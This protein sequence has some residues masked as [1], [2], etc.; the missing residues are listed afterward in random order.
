LFPGG[1][2]WPCA[3]LRASA[4]LQEVLLGER[5]GLAHLSYRRALTLA[6]REATPATWRG[7]LTAAKNLRGATRDQRRNAAAERGE[8][9]V[10]CPHV[11]GTIVKLPITTTLRVRWPDLARELE[12]SR[13]LVARSRELVEE[14]RRL[15]TSI[16][17]ENDLGGG[18]RS[19]MPPPE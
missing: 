14:S 13:Q 10:A 12:R 17:T 2:N 16:I 6:Q 5:L 18:R 9:E 7:L 1:P 3:A 19:A 11:P 8:A 4:Y 15:W